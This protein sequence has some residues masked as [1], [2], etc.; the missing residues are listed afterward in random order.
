MFK[1]ADDIHSR[2]IKRLRIFAGPNGAGK[3]SIRLAVHSQG[4][5]LGKWLNADD[6]LKK[7]EV[8][9]GGVSTKELLESFDVEAFCTFYKKHSL[10]LSHGL[11]WCFSY[12]Q[13][14][15]MLAMDSK[16]LADNIFVSYVMSVLI[17]YIR[18]QLLK[19]GESFSFETVFSHKSKLEFMNDA[20]R[21]GY[22][23][24][25]YFVCIE[26]PELCISRVAMRVAL[27]GHSVPVDKIIER[28][29]RCLSLLP[30]A[31]KIADRIYLF[32]NSETASKAESKSSLVVEIERTGDSFS[33]LFHRSKLP[34]WILNHIPFQLDFANIC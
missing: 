12:T 16:T 14:T 10:V 23:I 13:S 5:H 11:S 3:S 19:S 4:I 6:L 18:I 28:Y 9:N 7:F 20:K 21:N 8:N 33:T 24:Y 31:I 25:L 32:D 1:V 15:A 34:E 27:G 2:Q 22:R 26:P 17:D 30:D 29:G